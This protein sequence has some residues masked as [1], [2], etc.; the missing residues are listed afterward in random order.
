MKIKFKMRE[1]LY[2]IC[3]FEVECE[4]KEQSSFLLDEIGG[5][6][7]CDDLGEELC[8]RL[9]DDNVVYEGAD[10]NN[11]QSYDEVDFWDYDN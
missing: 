9:G 1:E 5:D 11:I 2:A 3:D 8:K 10:F 4:S 6:M 7:S